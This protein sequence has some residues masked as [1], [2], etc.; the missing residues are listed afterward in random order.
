ML[1]TDTNGK[2]DV[3]RWERATNQLQLLSSATGGGQSNGASDE[4]SLTA[5]GTKVAFSSDAS[6][7]VAGDSNGQTDVFVVDLTTGKV[8]RV[9]LKDAS[10][11]V[12]GNGDSF[13]PSI[14]ADGNMIAFASEATNLTSVS[15]DNDTT[16]VFLRD[17]TDPAHPQTDLLSRCTGNVGNDRSFAP[18][19][20]TD[21][22]PGNAAAGVS[23]VSDA[24]NLLTGCKSPSAS[25]DHNNASDV[26]FRPIRQSP[27]SASAK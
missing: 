12:P 5:A 21:A 10:T 22:T 16:D 26:Y 9:S 25:D 3:Y 1:T 7:L 11:T 6:D 8:E 13:S 23:F 4:P 14:S 15:D 17:R 24:T 18:R 27:R 19:I 20:S 2:S